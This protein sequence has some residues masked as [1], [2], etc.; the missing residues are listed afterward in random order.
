MISERLK[1]TRIFMQVV[2]KCFFLSPSIRF[3]HFGLQFHFKDI[4]FSALRRK[5]LLLYG[6]RQNKLVVIEADLLFQRRVW[7]CAW[8]MVYIWDILE[9]FEWK[10]AAFLKRF[11]EIT[12]VSIMCALFQRREE[13]NT[14]E[15]LYSMVLN[16]EEDIFL[17]HHSTPE[18]VGKLLR[19]REIQGSLGGPLKPLHTRVG[20]NWT[21]DSG[22]TRVWPWPGREAGMGPMKVL[23]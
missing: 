4:V 20:P 10:R 18:Q 5:S 19:P 13:E 17:W 15:R 3:W 8:D 2:D 12:I 16:K 11:H 1:A 6:L 7:I 21:E 23:I 14:L 22:T 9:L